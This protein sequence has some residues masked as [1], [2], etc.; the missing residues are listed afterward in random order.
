MPNARGLEISALALIQH[1]Q[2]NLV[3]RY[4]RDSI[5]KELLQNAEDARASVVHFG[6]SP[7]LA[8][9]DQPLLW[10]PALFT[11]N[12]GR[13]SA[14]DAKAI[15]QF[16]LNYKTADRN[17]IGKFG[18]GLKSVFHL[19]EAFFYLSSAR[20]AEGEAELFNSV[21][22]PWLNTPHHPDWNEFSTTDQELVRQHL[23]P[24]LNG[25]HWFCLW[26]PLRR[27]G[28]CRGAAPI[29]KDFPGDEP[30]CPPDLLDEA[31]AVFLADQLP[32][33]RRV[34]QISVWDR[35][36]GPKAAGTPLLV[37]S[38]P[39]TASRSRFP[40]HLTKAVGA[41]EA[42]TV[43]ARSG[44][45]TM[46]YA[47]W[48]TWLGPLEEFRGQPGWPQS[49][50]L[51][52]DG[53]PRPE[54]AEPHCAVSLTRH[55]VDDQ[56]RLVISSAVFL[57]LR[58]TIQEYPCE[59][60]AQYSLKLHGC[61]FVDAGR[62]RPAVAA[63]AED[64]SE[65]SDETRLKHKWNRRLFEEGVYP[66]LI[67]TVAELAVVARVSDD[68]LRGLTKAIQGSDTF[69]DN[70]QRVC[71]SWQWV[72]RWRPGRFL[73]ERVS[74][75]LPILEI[76]DPGDSGP[77]L[78][79]QA[80]PR[81]AELADRYALTL[82]GWPR[83]SAGPTV[84]W[85]AD[86]LGI[87]LDADPESL[88][89]EDGRRWG[90]VRRFI[91]TATPAAT[92]PQ[93]TEALAA[94]LRRTFAAVGTRSLRDQKD[95]V[96]SVVGGLPAARRLSLPLPVNW[97]DK[98]RQA[99]LAEPAGVVLIPDE[100]APQ[101][102]P[103][104]GRLVAEEVGRLLAVLQAP[105]QKTRASG[106]A[107]AVL[108]A[109][110]GETASVLA[111]CADLP[112]WQGE[113]VTAD[114]PAQEVFS[115]ARLVQVRREKLLFAAS[116]GS[117]S[118]AADL[119][120]AL[121]SQEVVLLPVETAEVVFGKG[122]IPTCEQ[123][124]VLAALAAGPPLADTGRR[125]RLLEYLLTRP[126]SGPESKAWRGGVRYL[127]HGRPESADEPFPLY[128]GQRNAGGVWAKLARAAL[129]ASGGGWRVIPPGPLTDLLLWEQHAQSLKVCGIDPESV[130]QLLREVGPEKIDIGFGPQE[131]EEVLS[132]L[133]E[134]QDI[135]KALPL[136]EGM[137][138]RLHRIG[139]RSYWKETWYT[140]EGPLA[141][142]V[143]LLRRCE[144]EHLAA[145][146]RPLAPVLNP[147]EVLKFAA[148]E[149]AHEYWDTVMDALTKAGTLP[150]D[151]RA[152]L[153]NMEWLPLRGGGAAAP[154]R[155]LY[156]PD[157][158][159]A[160]AGVLPTAPA[161]GPV[162]PTALRAD[163]GVHRGFEALVRHKLFPARD[164]LLSRLGGALQAQERFR[165]GPLPFTGAD[166]IEDWLQAFRDA[167]SDVMPVRDL[168]AC[169]H[170][171]D[172]T[173]CRSHFI[174]NLT[175][176]IA[177]ERLERVLTFLRERHA[178]PA[179]TQLS[180]LLQVHNAYLRV[181]AADAAGFP[182]LL[183]RLR[184]RNQVGGWADPTRL[185]A[186]VTGIDPAETLDRDQEE[187]VRHR[188]KVQKPREFRA[189][190]LSAGPTV[191]HH[192]AAE[193]HTAVRYLE[194]YFDR[195]AAASEDVAGWAGAF[196]S[197]MGDFEPVR[198]LA[199]KYLPHGR[200]PEYVRA[201]AGLRE[202]T[203]EAGG[204]KTVT[205]GPVQIMTL[206]RFLVEVTEPKPTIRVVNLLG[207]AFN[208]RAASRTN[209][210]LIG[211][212]L[213][214]LDVLLEG[215]LQVHWL[216]LRRIDPARTDPADLRRLLE[217]TADRILRE[218]YG[219][220]DGSLRDVLTE[221][222]EGEEF[223]VR[224]AQ[225]VLLEGAGHYL[226]QFGLTS[227]PA[228]REVLRHYDEAAD[229]RAEERAAAEHCR[230]LD[231]ETAEAKS[232]RA[233]RRLQEL[234]ETDK[235]VRDAILAAVR[236]KLSGYRYHTGSVLFEP[237]QNADDAYVERGSEA[238]GVF[239]VVVDAGGLT[240][241]HAGRRI[242]RPAGAGADEV[243]HVRDLRKMLALGHS[244]KGLDG[245]EVTGRFGLGFK[246][247]FLVCDQPRAVSGRLGFEVLGAVY[248]R[249]LGKEPAESLRERLKAV[250]LP[251]QEGSAFE[252]LLCDGVTLGEILDPFEDLAHLLVVFARRVRR[253]S[254]VREDGAT[255]E[256]SWN[257]E[258]VAAAGEVRVTTGVLRPA[259]GTAYAGPR[260][261]VL[262]RTPD[263]DL[264]LA[265]NARG[266]VP[267]P[268]A[269]PTVWV[270][271]PTE[272][273]HGL[274]WAVN[275]LFALDVGRSQVDWPANRDL[276]ARL[277]AGVGEG[278]IALFDV[279]LGDGIWQSFAARLRLADGVTPQ[280]FWES[281]WQTLSGATGGREVLR[282]LLWG[283]R[284]GGAARLYAEKRAL[285]TGL[286][287]APY[288][289]L[290][291]AEEVHFKACG[292]LDQRP[293]L[294]EQVSAWDSFRRKFLPG[295][296]VS[297]ERIWQPLQRLC[298]SLCLDDAKEVR[299]QDALSDEL[300]PD[301]AADPDTAIR[302]GTAV[303]KNFVD[304]VAESV[305]VEGLLRLLSSVQFLARDRRYHPA[306]ELL[307][308]S[309]FRD[310]HADE[311]LR[312]GFAPPERVLSKDYVGAG[313]EFFL[314]C[315]GPMEAEL[316]ANPEE[317][318]EWAV[319]AET[320]SRRRSVIE[321]L[322]RGERKNDLAVEIREKGTAGTWLGLLSPDWN[323]YPEDCKYAGYLNSPEWAEKREAVRHRCQGVCENC[324]VRAMEDVHHRHYETF[325]KEDLKDLQGLC[326]ECHAAIHGLNDDARIR[327]GIQDPGS[328]Y[329]DWLKQRAAVRQ[330]ENLM[331]LLGLSRTPP[332][333]PINLAPHPIPEYDP[334]SALLRIARWW[335]AEGTS[336]LR[337]Y[338]R[339]TYPHGRPP[340][341][342]GGRPG[343]DSEARREW[344]TLF[345]TGMMLTL[346]RGQGWRSQNR[347]FLELCHERGWLG[348]LADPAAG[349]TNW[350]RAVEEYIDRQHDQIPY[351]H[352]L[353]QFIGIVTVARYLDAYAA[354]F[355]APD[356]IR[357]R[358]SL[359]DLLAPRASSHFQG[360]GVDA[361]PVGP[362]LG[363]GAH[364]V[365][366][367]L[368]R[369]GVVINRRVYRYC[370]PPV[371]R[372]RDF[373][374][375]RLGWNDKEGR[376]AVPWARSRSIYNFLREHCPDPT[377]GRAFDL[378]LLALAEDPTL[379]AAVLKNVPPVSG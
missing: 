128:V 300:G 374:A 159:E 165:V 93:A 226:R 34:G 246:S 185:C 210:L 122:E 65:P 178:S 81:L 224:S 327:G 342:S 367:E 147:V 248:P 41:A 264:L 171:V 215:D 25:P 90:Y 40:D 332:P 230:E 95:A 354:C 3:D 23:A 361:P 287:S 154:A 68:A 340:Q 253:F 130:A 206:Q 193:W 105:C 263:G 31:K 117:A 179:A 107:R 197:L 35:W 181:A 1:L 49:F 243:G 317:M 353:R 269:V 62:G 303:G 205:E 266:F 106:T 228:L 50:S 312:A 125:T 166:A 169:V 4:P 43:H 337:Q 358:F 242:N 19:C 346:G 296:M 247:V 371:Q 368:V 236:R 335:D 153:A 372:L 110:E 192:L 134:A 249:A 52:D 172:P 11:V 60:R 8:T 112:L 291:R 103:G 355:L 313:L 12:D 86:A 17:S 45:S 351:F 370:Y 363:T 237:F 187:V 325:G 39:P 177:A 239:A 261:A 285:P 24:L 113:R 265:V 290:T 151:L 144:K 37:A 77:D 198:R 272:E 329:R 356:Q 100:F 129:E 209:D 120:A 109:A 364:F 48:Q 212:G 201:A 183:P 18:L 176:E 135:L 223:G 321:Y 305:E 83:L 376:S 47:L 328:P 138:G 167:P 36:D 149:S 32:L 59:D 221:L 121:A 76:P 378:P 213:R 288:R 220:K 229:R 16:G 189:A 283:G 254:L 336:R 9:A 160:I 330:K 182:K 131:Q 308:P 70:R 27:E 293:Q 132:R 194:N 118:V 233:R 362:V 94:L 343:D 277:G 57:P 255:T 257:D 71:S 262:V 324:R 301:H 359:R 338:E 51:A 349:S 231:G 38:V 133:P 44:E 256:V 75:D 161:G 284:T 78:P 203:R 56:G 250:G 46:A 97:S 232:D 87:V 204:G 344:L 366:R 281:L 348:L 225:A 108:A 30:A 360:T 137:D 357:D 373:I 307:L 196:L 168:L 323:D 235:E 306:Q 164:Q 311:A 259:S 271:A 15:C 140:L 270:T 73:W 157:L 286:S 5:S 22:N 6:W 42:V 244:D 98:D 174:P 369:T 72:Y 331:D 123:P 158:Q 155:V 99:V 150:S 115:Y 278:L 124:G 240:V 379:Q 26:V 67:P 345:L 207:E 191:G 180:K 375:S 141:A 245:S 216:H 88:F 114:G 310:D 276:A 66:L 208:A 101:D 63:T 10:G 282:S 252:L 53:K 116:A 227:P 145:I 102:V 64:G 195:W 334:E 326:A 2:H 162:S 200:S 319:R 33:L 7:G 314:A 175:G 304:Q 92:G 280:E 218:V 91:D 29:H 170:E 146:Q 295:C 74:V 352:W 241:M 139:A 20:P 274:G 298:P 234:I 96:R 80:L 315:R 156:D 184:L 350:L 173:M 289:L 268:A 292:V 143:R 202:R 188:V 136:H 61:F 148:A 309:P 258:T 347:T 58:G 111:R 127:L 365:L 186:G 238:A 13:F 79:G 54:K 251:G 275:A 260:Q 318:A 339:E 69:R 104:T 199:E 316:E 89:A 322:L 84:P 214:K 211:Y 273:R 163:V 299:L 21:V 279:S 294:F 333:R 302:L 219:Q 377:F 217:E 55:P 320:E 341:L 267:L 28:H 126:P 142:K 222:C 190:D 82:S 14:Q 119:A 85:P 297:A 152:T